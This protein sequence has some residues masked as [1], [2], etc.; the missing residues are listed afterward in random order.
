MPHILGQ[1][2]LVKSKHKPQDRPAARGHSC[3]H[4]LALHFG[5]ELGEQECPRS[6]PSSGLSQIR[7]LRSVVR[8]RRYRGLDKSRIL[9]LRNQTLLP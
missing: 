9:I 1:L 8:D 5:A 2:H 3:A 7:L 4:K 6:S